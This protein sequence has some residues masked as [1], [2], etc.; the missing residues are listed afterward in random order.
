[1][2]RVA[3]VRHSDPNVR[4]SDEAVRASDEAVCAAVAAANHEVVAIDAAE[5]LVVALHPASPGL[6]ERP[7]IPTVAILDRSTI[8]PARDFEELLRASIETA[9]DAFVLQPA[10]LADAIAWVADEDRSARTRGQPRLTVIG[11]N[12]G[13]FG[14]TRPLTAEPMIIG[15]ASNF[16]AEHPVR[17]DRMPTPIGTIARWHARAR[18]VDGVVSVCDLRSTNGTLLIRWGEPARLL[19]PQQLQGGRE[20]GPPA[21]AWLVRDP[22]PDYVELR[23]G[24][25]LQ[26]PGGWRF[27]VDGDPQT[28]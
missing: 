12:Q 25:H 19:C 13:D 23:F 8:A 11:T 4:G 15:R 14:M 27:R 26:L 20:Y 2:T 16:R 9:A 24:D 28:E 18:C 10:H 22:T 6:V 1:M 3:F 7:A 17:P 21:S 5:V